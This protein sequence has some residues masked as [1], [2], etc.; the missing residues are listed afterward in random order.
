MNIGC[1][2]QEPRSRPFQSLLEAKP[3]E[4]RSHLRVLYLCQQCL[5]QVIP[6]TICLQFSDDLL[7]GALDC[8][9]AAFQIISQS[10]ERVEFVCRDGCFP[11]QLRS[12]FIE[13]AQS[14]SKCIDSPD[15]GVDIHR[16]RD[17]RYQRRPR[18]LDQQESCNGT[19]QDQ[20]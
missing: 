16:S 13:F 6:L 18:V 7:K 8:R 3:L 15:L 10:P 17:S 20:L 1:I 11:G 14:V 9:H 4:E 5:I 19:N 12:P 2:V